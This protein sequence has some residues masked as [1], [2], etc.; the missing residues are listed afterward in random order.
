ML[1][2]TLKYI[3]HH[4]DWQNVRQLCFLSL[5]I[6]GFNSINFY[7]VS[8]YLIN[9]FGGSYQIY[10]LPHVWGQPNSCHPLFQSLWN[11]SEYIHIHKHSHTSKHAHTI[12]FWLQLFLCEL[13]N[14]VEIEREFSR[15]RAVQ[16]SLE[17]SCPVLTKDVLATCVLLAHPCHSWIYTLSTVYVLH[18]RLPKE[19]EYI[20]PN[21]IWSNKI[22][23]CKRK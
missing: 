11:A 21:V 13:T 10:F 8:Y 5:Q 1:P 15:N 12:C 22:W 19:E 7:S 16:S 3:V 9:N 23:F 17:I 18:S 2:Q 20:L 6:H 14:F 4:F